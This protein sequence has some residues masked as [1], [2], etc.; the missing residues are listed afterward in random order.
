VKTKGMFLGGSIVVACLFTC[1]FTAARAL[2][3]RRRPL[4]GFSIFPRPPP[5][6][7]T[8]DELDIDHVVAAP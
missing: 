2:H 7:T 1:S 4:S 8:N 3:R 5:L 6:A